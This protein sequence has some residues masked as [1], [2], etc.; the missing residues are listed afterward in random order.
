[1][2]TMKDGRALLFSEGRLGPIVLKNRLIR[3]AAFE[4]MTPEGKVS[5][6]LIEHHRSLAAGGIGMTTVAYCSVRP[7]GRTFPHQMVMSEEI[8][9]DLTRL[10]DAVHAEGAAA[11]IQL[12][13]AGLFADKSL[14]GG[15]PMGPS[16]QF[17]L[18]GMSYGRAMSASEIQDMVDSFRRAAAMAGE[19][20]FDAVELH[21][22]HGYL[23]SQFV[24]PHSNRRR[25]EWGGSLENRLRFPFAVVDAVLD[26][27]GA[28]RAVLAKMNM[29]DGYHGGLQLDDAV[30]VAMA[31]EDHGVSGLVLSGGD[32][33]KTPFYMLR[34]KVPVR[35]MVATQR[36]MLRKV[37][38]TLF[39]RM[40]VEAYRYEPLFFF[41]PARKIRNAVQLPLVYVGG[42]TNLTDMVAVRKAGFEFVALGRALIYEPDFPKSLEDGSL[43]AVDCDHCN[44]CVAAMEAGG[45][46]CVTRDEARA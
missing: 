3:T 30:R 43:E 40:L 7:E 23:L 46:R 31:L 24:S 26:E 12:G 19:A 4:G 2:N 10:V 14:A 44:R 33:S 27:I 17:N 28:K 45:I 36:G 22:G 16:A 8:L 21:L 38:L 34:G 20:G 32:V 37:G 35:E 15:R 5:D 1:M 18:Y 13:H 39:G 11:S 41:E 25:D 29:R 9:P 42:A 6:Q